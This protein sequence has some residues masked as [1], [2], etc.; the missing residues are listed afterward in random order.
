MF[1]TYSLQHALMALGGS[2]PGDVNDNELKESS[3]PSQRT[4]D[5]EHDK[6]YCI[7]GLYFINIMLRGD[8]ES[9]SFT[10]RA[11]KVFWSDTERR[12]TSSI[13][14]NS[15]NFIFLGPCSEINE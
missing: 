7:E 14:C 10:A 11:I 15:K 1:W 8:E 9:E 3:E 6:R 13:A 4:G 12:P 5:E 2:F